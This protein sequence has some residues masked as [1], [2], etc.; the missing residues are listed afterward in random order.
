LK[1]PFAFFVVVAN[2]DMP[3]AGI[4]PIPSDKAKVLMLVQKLGVT[5]QAEMSN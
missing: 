4:L 3:G 5:K 1:V 2:P